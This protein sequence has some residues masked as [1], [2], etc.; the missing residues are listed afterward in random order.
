MSTVTLPVQHAETVSQD[1]RDVATEVGEREGWWQSGEI[2]R[3]S[4]ARAHHGKSRWFSC[5]FDG[6]T[7]S[8]P[9][10][11][12]EGFIERGED[13][14]NAHWAL[15]D[16]LGNVRCTRFPFDRALIHLPEI[17]NAGSNV[18]VLR[19][20]PY[21]RCTLRITRPD[22]RVPL[23]AKVFAN[24]RGESVER[25]CAAIWHAT[26]SGKLR[27]AVARPESWDK[28]SRVMWQ[29]QVSGE[30]IVPTLRGQRGET[31]AAR[32]GW[33][34]AS[35]VS[36]GIEA[37]ELFTIRDQLERSTRFAEHISR[38]APSLRVRVNALLERLE[39]L[40][41]RSDLKR[42]C[43]IHGSL[44]AHQWL[45]GDDGLGLVDFD[46]FCL[47]EPEL[48]AATMIAELDYEHHASDALGGAFLAA[49]EDSAGALDRRVFQAYRAHKH[50][51]KAARAIRS[52]KAN[53]IERAT[54][55]LERAMEHA[56]LCGG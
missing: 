22:V 3:A 30:P 23:I 26:Q 51:S 1:A 5:V 17:V 19:Y 8:A 27:F 4:Y 49:Y 9:R 56:E 36:S 14:E 39:R 34:S 13:G 43:P 48:D 7:P 50:L 33:A 54:L 35:L 28:R 10:C 24:G 2:L 42:L 11:L 47:G 6:G 16:R 18:Q 37:R 31:L 52:L 46:R 41:P 44:H 40:H 29:Y 25:D 55:C 32:L 53:A 21:K 45:D 20:R 15:H 12:V 38:A